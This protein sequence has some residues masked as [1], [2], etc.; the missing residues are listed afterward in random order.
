MLPNTKLTA[1]TAVTSLSRLTVPSALMQVR[2]DSPVGRHHALRH[3]AV[4]DA[5]RPP[6]GPRPR[7][8]RRFASAITTSTH[9]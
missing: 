1:Q 2:G 9:V 7:L 3:G 5:G 8:R 4:T 6:V